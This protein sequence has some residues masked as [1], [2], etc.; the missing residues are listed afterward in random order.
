MDL[1]NA[2]KQLA[3]APADAGVSVVAVWNPHRARCELFEAWAMPF[4]ATAAVTRFNRCSAAL[5]YLLA[6]ELHVVSSSYFDDFSVVSP[7]V[8]ADSTDAAVKEFFEL[9]GWP[10]KEAKDRPFET[11]FK[12]LGVVFDFADADVSGTIRCG[13]TAERVEELRA[14]LDGILRD[15]ALTAPMAS[16]LAGRLIFAR[17]QTFG[18]SGGVAASQVFRRSR[19]HGAVRLDHRLRWALEWWRKFF[20]DAS[21]RVVQ[22][23]RACAPVLLWTDGAHE[24]S[25]VCPTTCGAL[26]VD[27]SR[28]AMECFGVAVPEDVRRAWEDFSRTRLVRDLWSCGLVASRSPLLT[29]RFVSCVGVPGSG[30]DCLAEGEVA[31]PSFPLFSPPLSVWVVVR[32][33]GHSCPRR[34][35]AAGLRVRVR[36]LRSAVPVA[37]LS[38]RQNCCP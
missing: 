29:S 35:G 8:L 11:A 31:P 20:C 28:G 21:P 30:G 13:N 32:W 17:S 9:I 16:H 6:A 4:G 23:G 2:Y 10:L 12:A 26:I 15:D 3:V 1:A 37:S 33:G 34:F 5:E 14:L 24:A 36:D 38:D 19:E 7:E 27:Q 25:A 22:V 18:R